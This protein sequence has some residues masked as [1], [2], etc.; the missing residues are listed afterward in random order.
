LY[1]QNQQNQRAQSSFQPTGYVQS[2]YNSNQGQNAFSNQFL[3][4]QLTNQNPQ[5][6]LTNAVSPQSYHTASYQ[7]DQQGHDQYLRADSVRPSQQ[8]FGQNQFGQQNQIGQSQFGQQNQIGRSQFGQQNQIGQSQF[9]QQN[10]IGQSQFGQNQLNQSQNPQSFHAANY[11]GNQQGHDQYL[12]A[13]STQPSQNQ[14][15][16]GQNQFQ[17]QNQNQFQNQ[18]G[19]S[20]GGQNQQGQNPQSFHTANYRGNQQGHDQYLRADSFQPSQQSRGFN[21]GQGQFN[22]F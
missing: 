4:N 16:S 6:Q 21:Q 19:F 1:Q 22:Q 12:R 7:G 10:Q 13:D 11:R 2:V 14:G 5:Q 8:Q 20:A 15:Y 9:G 17:N 18:I 3:N